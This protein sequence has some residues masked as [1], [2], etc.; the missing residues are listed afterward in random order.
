MG[1]S[2]MSFRRLMRSGK[3]GSTIPRHRSKPLS[4][5]AIVIS[6]TLVGAALRFGTL[7]VQSVWLDESTTM[8]LVR[9]SLAGMFSHL[10]NEETPPL[11]FVLAWFW[12]RIFGVGV[13][14]F[15]SL[16][17]LLGTI[18][19]PVMYATGR[20]IS[21]RVGLWAAALTTVNPAMYYYSQ[22][23]RCYA[24]LILFS[25]AAFFFWLR[26]LQEGD[27]RSLALWSA[28][29]VLALLTHYF[30]IF[31]FIP[32]ALLLM[33]RL[34]SRRMLAPVIPVILTGIALVPLALWQ[35]STYSEVLEST[36][37]ASRAAGAVK[38]FLVG[39]YGP[40]EVYSALLTGLLVVLAV[41]LLWRHGETRLR[42]L[43]LQI[44]SVG[45]V[46]VLL[47]LLLAL[48][49][50]VAYSF[51]GRHLIA[52][53]IPF[54]LLVAMGLGVAH[55]RRMGALLGLALCAISIAVIVGIDTIPGYQ[56]DNWRGVATALSSH[57]GASVIVTPSEGFVPL[58]IYLPRLEL[59]S[60][61]R[62]PA[63][64]L[65]FVALRSKH[66]GHAPLPPV[67]STKP[68]PGYRLAEVKRTETYAIARF[69]APRAMTTSTNVLRRIAME[70]SA[71]VLIHR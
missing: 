47:P 41:A 15:R 4:P 12:T 2:A 26:A 36:S 3:P 50:I 16:S 51:E 53:W 69:L 1:A 71:E 67:V 21:P 18:T 52:A 29:S 30:A 62:Y 34:G 49:H 61:S 5:A 13:I 43:A 14:G 35:S 17:A 42:W 39:L 23:A 19:I 31:M 25:S 58:S 10:Y 63:R 40:L 64:E 7:D 70:A 68:P 20:R 22:E 60:A 27:G 28:M 56:R 57:P 33:R 8:V 45:A 66:T 32:E 59:V 24:L 48:M 37:T 11:Y 38:Q 9:R 55:D 44:G 65:E 54:A 6:L 46:A